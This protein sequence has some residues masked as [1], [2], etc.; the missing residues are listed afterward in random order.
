M[1]ELFLKSWERLLNNNFIK[2]FSKTI[3][4]MEIVD[5]KPRQGKIE[6]VAEVT[7]KGDVREFNKFG[8][9]GRVCNAKIKDSSGEITLTLWNDDIDN[10]NVGDKIRIEN[11]YVSEWQGELQLTTGKFGKLEILEKGEEPKK[12]EEG[13]EE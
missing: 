1:K 7:E 5:L 12:K 9:T 10:V 13:K 2:D 3:Y 4:K 11:G 6:I 8:K